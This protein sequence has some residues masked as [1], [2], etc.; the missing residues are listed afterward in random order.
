MAPLPADVQ[1]A[2]AAPVDV[3]LAFALECVR[4]GA[5][6]GVRELF[7]GSFAALV[8]QAADPQG[9]DPAFQALVTR[10]NDA[11]VREFVALQS[12]HPGRPDHVGATRGDPCGHVRGDRR[13]SRGISRLPGSDQV[14]A[15][16]LVCVHGF[17]ST[18]A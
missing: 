3:A 4:T 8:A 15:V 10:A 2:A 12:Q 14:R 7:V 9:G 5:V 6:A 17:T 18:I 1:A 11:T 13:L 16:P